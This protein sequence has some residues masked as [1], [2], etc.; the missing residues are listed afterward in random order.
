[1]W[2]QCLKTT[3]L[4]IVDVRVTEKARLPSNVETW[5]LSEARWQRRVVV[6]PQDYSGF[7][8]KPQKQTPNGHNLP[9]A[10]PRARQA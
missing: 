10:R 9:R 2:Q 3:D 4:R 7:G 6:R 5:R 1:M 8:L